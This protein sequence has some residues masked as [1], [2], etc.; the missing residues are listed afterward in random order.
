MSKIRKKKSIRG[1]FSG[2]KGQRTFNY[3]YSIGASVVI[4]GSLFKILH[5]PGADLMLIIGMGT[6]AA[7]FFLSSF[8][9]P[10]KDYKWENVFPAL[11]DPN[12][13]PSQAPAFPQGG[14]GGGTVIIGNV[15]DG[16]VLSA[17]GSGVAA[18]DGSAPASVSI[19]A[20][21]PAAVSGGAG[22]PSAAAA[23]LSPESAAEL[24][25]A[26]ERYVNQINE[27]TE[28]L[29]MLKSVTASLKE[30]QSSLLASYDS[31]MGDSTAG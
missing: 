14:G 21:A 10:A 5:L 7:I 22:I 31:L 9:E 13:D 19:S 20:G 8:D 15:P 24:N 23:A 4:L 1:F 28:Q 18:A 11:D 16:A 12:A 3:A 2:D 26:T 6:E 17:G 30:A 25:S 27:M 29:L